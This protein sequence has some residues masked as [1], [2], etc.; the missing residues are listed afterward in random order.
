[1]KKE[2]GNYDLE[3]LKR[4]QQEL[5]EKV[6]LT[7][8]FD[9]G[10][11]EYVAGVDQSFVGE[12]VISA[13]ALLKFPSLEP[14]R[15]KTTVENVSFP[16]IPT[17]LMFREG[18]PAVRAVSTTIED[19]D[20]SKVAVVV[21]GSGI[22]HPRKCG[23]ACY[24]AVKTDLPT[25]GITKKRLFGEVEE[26]QEVLES[27]PIMDEGELIGYALKTCKRCRPI[28]I[29]PGGHITPQNALLFIK[30]CIK[31]YKLPEPVRMAHELATEARKKRM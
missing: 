26:P 23:L 8:E 12:K 20:K 18:M 11:M 7:D 1:M 13:C 2:K 28:Y 27:R 24:V 3:E 21:D 30:E 5:A 17:F 4:S 6:V 19:I 16:Y 22:A 15:G 9:L 14:V 10:G 25:I 31:G 29:S